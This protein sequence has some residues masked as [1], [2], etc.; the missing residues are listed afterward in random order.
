MI[1]LLTTVVAAGFAV[2]LLRRAG[3]ERPQVRWWAFGVVVYG[4]GTAAAA[5]LE[6]YGWSATGF[7]LWYITGAVLGGS[8][9]ALGSVHLL[10]RPPVARQI[11]QSVL[12]VALGA[13]VATLMAPVAPLADGTLG[14]ASIGWIWVRALTPILNGF[15]VIYLVGGAARSALRLAR[16]GEG[17]KR[18]VAG[19]V[20][21]AIGGI[22][23]ALGG[24]ASRLGGETALAPTLLAGLLLIW[25]GARLSAAGGA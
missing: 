12:T 4:T 21:L 2:D 10:H 6:R 8:V 9:L 22:T 11:T 7:R 20:T 15:A 13:A 23:P 14:G 19:N 16:R 3:R 18:R 17:S 5:H 25:A 24:V 1:S